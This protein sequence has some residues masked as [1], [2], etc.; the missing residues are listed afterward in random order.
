MQR[1]RF[2][3]EFQSR[4]YSKSGVA[5]RLRPVK[6]I[7]TTPHGF[8]P[9]KEGNRAVTVIIFGKRLPLEGR[10]V[11]PERNALLHPACRRIGAACAQAE[12]VALQAL[13]KLRPNHLRPPKN[14]L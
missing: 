4:R 7:R 3:P 6:L 2:P 14:T 8:P 12:S 13:S 11:S 9:Q 1:N 10:S 5:R